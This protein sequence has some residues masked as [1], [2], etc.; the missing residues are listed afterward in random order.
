MEQTSNNPTPAN[1]LNIDNPINNTYVKPK[2]SVVK[3]LLII[4]V[5][6]L[7]AVTA[8]LVVT[9]LDK[10][11]K[12]K[13]TQKELTSTKT[14]LTTANAKIAELDNPQKE[15]N[16]LK[17]KEDLAKFAAALSEYSANHNGVY[18]STEP[19]S[20]KKEFTDI[21]ITNK[22]KNFIDPVTK[23][24]YEFTPVAKVQTPP[25]VTLGNIQYQWPG[26]CAGSEFDDNATE[27]DA[28]VRLILESGDIYCLAL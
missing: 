17:R 7:S 28:A 18:P 21:Y 27:R 22:F 15:I 19:S 13:T 23:K 9:L 25:G 26:K 5:I 8:L 11:S 10:D 2:S 4:L 3:I 20:F 16:D 6:I 12:L 14:E 1:Q 24:A